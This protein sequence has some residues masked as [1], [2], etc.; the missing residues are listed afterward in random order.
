MSFYY[1]CR[2]KSN[3]GVFGILIGYMAKYFSTFTPGFGEVVRAEL[4]KEFSDLRVELLVDGLILYKTEA[5]IG[6]VSPL[7]FLNNSLNW[8]CGM[9]FWFREKKLEFLN[10]GR[11]DFVY[12]FSEGFGIADCDVG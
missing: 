4:E 3:Y 11:F 8:M 2:V 1:F 12:D 10:S 9:I 6:E 5:S 7:R